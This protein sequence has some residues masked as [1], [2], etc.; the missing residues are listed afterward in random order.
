MR[1]GTSTYVETVT[2]DHYADVYIIQRNKIILVC[3]QQAHHFVLA[4]CP[5]TI[6]LHTHILVDMLHVVVLGL[7]LQVGQ[8][9]AIH[10]EHSV[11]GFVAVVTTIAKELCSI[12]FIGVDGLVYPVPDGSTADVIA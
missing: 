7:R 8:H 9:H 12:R 10:A 6:Q 2:H 3:Y 1:N 5:K 11:V 4:H